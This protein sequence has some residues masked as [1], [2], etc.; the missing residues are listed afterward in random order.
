MAKQKLYWWIQHLDEIGGTEMVSIDLANHL[1]D[2]FDITLIV[3]S[4][5]IKEKAYKLDERIKIFTLN[6]PHEVTRADQYSLRYKQEHHHWKAFKLGFKTFVT[7]TFK[8]GHY[9]RMVKKLIKKEPGILIC[10]SG[11]SYYFA[12]R[13]IKTIFHYHFNSRLF[14]SLG[15]K[16]IMAFSRKPDHSIFLSKSTL[17]VIASKKKRYRKNSSYIYNPVRFAP[18]LDET[19]Y[20]N[21]IIFVGRFAE[22]K[23]PL[24]ALG[25]ALELKK[26]NFPFTFD[27]YGEGGL[28]DKMKEYISSNELENYVHIHEPI[29]NIKDEL[30]KSDLLLLTSRYEGLVLVKAEA[31]AMSTPVI[32]SNWGDT[33]YEITSEGKDGYIIDSD[34]PSIY[35]DKIIEVLS[36]KEKLKELKRTSYECSKTFSYERIIPSWIDLLHK[37]N[38]GEQK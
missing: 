37:L 7:Y 17:D 12:P 10:S 21:R 33:V 5:V 8:S 36:D 1:C 25:V 2:E 24:L 31:N 18:E 20:N 9:K 27:M 38:N 14:F 3:S 30:K 19:Y 35:A 28:L 34:D 13:K 15:N 32:S 4:E 22:Q 11:E 16:M 23:N 6:I 29:S 26:R